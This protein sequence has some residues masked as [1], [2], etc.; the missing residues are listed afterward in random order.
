MVPRRWRACPAT[1]IEDAPGSRNTQR[2]LARPTA[3]P[4]R[5]KFSLLRALLLEG[6]SGPLLEALRARER[7]LARCDPGRLEGCR[8][9]RELVELLGDRRRCVLF[10]L[11]VGF[12]L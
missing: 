9:V 3:K 4:S 12:Q 5:G 2:A 7:R 1:W 8:G 6:G 11:Q 10:V